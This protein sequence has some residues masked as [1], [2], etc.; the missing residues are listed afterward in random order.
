M[1]GVRKMNNIR[2]SFLIVPLV[3]SGICFGCN[4]ETP[5][6]LPYGFGITCD[7]GVTIHIFGGKGPFH[8]DKEKCPAPSSN[9]KLDLWFGIY[10]P[11]SKEVVD[12]VIVPYEDYESN[13]ENYIHGSYLPNPESLPKENYPFCSSFDLSS[14]CEGNKGET[15]VAFVYNPNILAGPRSIQNSDFPVAPYITPEKWFHVSESTAALEE[16]KIQKIKQ[17]GVDGNDV[18]IPSPCLTEEDEKAILALRSVG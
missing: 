7:G 17:L 3:A 11:S 1:I 12:R 9:P 13:C 6:L 5:P 16:I 14:F 8:G 2:R 15:V 18:Y 4:V 10:K